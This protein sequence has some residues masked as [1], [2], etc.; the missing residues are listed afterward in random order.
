[1]E[2]IEVNIYQLL[3]EQEVGGSN[4]LAPTNDFK[5]LERVRVEPVLFFL[6]DRRW[7]RRYSGMFHHFSRISCRIVFCLKRLKSPLRLDIIKKA[8][9]RADPASF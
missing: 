5:H 3:W 4:P 2:G 7:D 1:M 8:G 9:P 6:I